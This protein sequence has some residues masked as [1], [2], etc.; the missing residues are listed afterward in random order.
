MINKIFFYR[1]NN[2]IKNFE[3]EEVV[4]TLP[5]TPKKRFR[6]IVAKPSI[7]K[8]NIRRDACQSGKAYKS[9]RGKCVPE[10]K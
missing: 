7:W 10:K 4:P 1:I 9:R 8:S 3:A 6:K 5:E 2:I